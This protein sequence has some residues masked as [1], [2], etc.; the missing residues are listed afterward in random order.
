MHVCHTFPVRGHSFLPNDRD[1]G[2][3]EVSKRKN[4]RV[5]MLDQWLYILSNKHEN[6]TLRCFFWRSLNVSQLQHP[7]RTTF[8]EDYYIKNAGKAFNIQR[9]R[10]LDYSVDHV[11]VV[12]VKYTLMDDEEG[13]KF[14]LLKARA[15]PSL[16]ALSSVKYDRDIPVKANKVSDIQKIVLKYVPSEFQSFYGKILAGDASSET[17]ESDD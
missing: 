14:S 15:V 7:L 6:E 12:W 8:Q 9:A 16:P 4:E 17:D 13:N 10:V 1:F 2:R 5:Y 3:T 11:S